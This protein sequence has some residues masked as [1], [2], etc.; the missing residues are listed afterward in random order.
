[1]RM[2]KP[3]F[4]NTNKVFIKSNNLKNIIGLILTTLITGLLQAQEPSTENK[5]AVQR[6]IINAF[7]ALSKKD[8]LMLKEYCATDIML[9]ENGATWNLDTLIKKAITLNTAPDF[10]RT[11]SFEFINTTVNKN[12][13]WVTYNL[14]SDV[15][16]D[17]KQS[18][19]KWLETVVLIKEKNHWKIKVLH[20]TLIKRS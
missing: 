17:T 2:I 7:D 20:S 15:T 13:A 4:N 11:N 9:F 19:I 1:M 18:A 12:I 10:K 14:S 8:S 6:T 3:G 5:Y 16:R